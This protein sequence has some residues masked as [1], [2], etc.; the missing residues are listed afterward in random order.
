MENEAG[1]LR[2]DLER[3]R[4][5]LRDVTDPRANAVIRELISEVETRLREINSAAKGRVGA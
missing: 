3:Y 2:R 1:K 4:F 5:L